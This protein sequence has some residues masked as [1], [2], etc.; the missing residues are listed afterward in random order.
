MAKTTLT[1]YSSSSSTPQR[2]KYDIFL[3]FKGEDTCNSFTSHLNQALHQRGIRTF[4]D[5]Q[6]TR[7]EEISPS[8]INAIQESKISIV[9]FSKN[10]TSPAWCLDELVMIL[11]RQESLGQLVW[12][13]FLNVE[14]S[15]VRNETGRF[16]D[17]LLLYEAPH[18]STNKSKYKEKLFKWKIAL[19]KAGNLSVW[20]F[21]EGDESELIQRI[22]EAT[23]SR[24]NRT[25]L[26]VA[27]YPVGID[28]RAIH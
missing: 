18:D 13:I 25:T 19:R 24:V 28:A 27:K 8:L 14:P 17:A 23:L 11:D 20:Y 21:N 4:K 2:L 9:I 10:Y 16:G 6:L 3:T 22:V 7:G 1:S 26:Y 15:H 12:P 5:N